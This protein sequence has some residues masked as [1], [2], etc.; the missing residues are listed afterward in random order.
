MANKASKANPS[1]VS[2]GKKKLGTFFDMLPAD[3]KAS[4]RRVQVYGELVLNAIIESGI[5]S[6]EE[7][8]CS[9]E[10]I[11]A[12][13]NA[14]KFYNIG[15]AALPDAFEGPTDLDGMT[16]DYKAH[17]GLGL[18]VF[19]NAFN[20]TELDG[21]A[22]FDW[23]ILRDILA[24]HHERWDGSG[25]PNG[26]LATE[27]PLSA[28][29]CAVCNYF[30]N[31]TTATE[32]R[33]KMTTEAAADEI[34]RRSNTYFDPA[35]VDAFISIIDKINEIF[36]NGTV[37]KATSGNGSVRAIEQLYRT[38]YDYG[39]HLQYGYYTDIR[40]N[41]AELGVIS[42]RIFLPI[43]EKSAKINEIVKWSVEE[44]CHTILY[45]KQ[46]KRFTGEFFVPLSVKSLLKKN[47]TDNIARI[48]DKNGVEASELCLVI[49]ENVFSFNLDRIAEALNELH[50]LGF[51]LAIGG[52]GS[53][54]VN[55]T[56]LQK[57]D[58]DYVILNSE[59]VSD[60][61]VSAKAKKIV[62]SVVDLAN[63]L[64]L[65]VIADGVAD[66]QQAKELYAMGCNIMCGPYYGRYTAA[67]II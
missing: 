61:L 34:S 43:A 21:K 4:S 59:F 56:A 31:L 1:K 33:D 48:V 64:D 32:D 53:E 42:S 66:K 10:G 8:L 57:L 14:L 13:K 19:D 6:N 16:D 60:I 27:I 3:L 44:T 38:V 52:F 36:E 22:A 7:P 55:L 9:Q 37:A 39:N 51:K 40:L 28:R 50:E 47:F 49:S 12:F 58:V 41:D 23:Q 67:A 26:L 30:E 63:K 45:M 25:Y 24:F 20:L 17:V 5:Y 29:V 54:S 2:I 62:A 65:T 35:V 11:V 18:D 46:R 15:V